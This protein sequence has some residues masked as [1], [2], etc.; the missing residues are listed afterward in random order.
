[1]PVEAASGLTIR[2][3]DLQRFRADEDGLRA[4]PEPGNF[5]QY[6]QSLA[7]PT[8]TPDARQFLAPRF[9]RFADFFASTLNYFADQSDD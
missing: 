1:M 4:I 3:L 8:I 6:H 9:D 2:E 5:H 7:D